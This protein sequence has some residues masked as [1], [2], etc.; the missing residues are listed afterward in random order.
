LEF[1]LPGSV[2]KEL[3]YFL[4]VLSAITRS[5]QIRFSSS[6]PAA[7]SAPTPVAVLAILLLWL[8]YVFI[9]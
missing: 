9:C 8:L 2:E 1:F 7:T 3:I 4:V 6:L 5:A